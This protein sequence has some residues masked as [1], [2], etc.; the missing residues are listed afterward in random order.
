MNKKILSNFPILEDSSNFEDI[1]RQCNALRGKKALWILPWNKIS[2]DE[3]ESYDE[4]Y[5]ADVKKSLSIAEK[6]SVEILLTPELTLF[7]LPSWVMQ[8]LSSLENYNG[9]KELFCMFQSRNETDQSC[10]FAFFLS[11][12]FASDLLFPEIQNDGESIQSFFQNQCIAAMKHSARRLKKATNVLGFYFSKM[13]SVDFLYSYMTKIETI[14]F[15]NKDINP[16][17]ILNRKTLKTQIDSF[18]VK[19]M[20]EILKKHEQYVFLSEEEFTTS[21]S[22]QS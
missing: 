6:S 9:T 3:P 12:F 14:T 20:N 19:Y 8:K 10:L 18:K 21:P 16:V 15:K 17:Q 22:F 4:A 2:L 11:L 1:E 7:S 5:L 13:L